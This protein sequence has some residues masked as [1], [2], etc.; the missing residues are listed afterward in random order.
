MTS[1]PTGRPDV[2][3]VAFGTLPGCD[4]NDVTRRL[5]TIQCAARGTAGG[6]VPTRQRSLHR[7]QRKGRP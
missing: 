2:V 3:G 4:G 5:W 1:S 6:A 7:P